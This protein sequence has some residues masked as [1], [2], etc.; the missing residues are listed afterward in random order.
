MVYLDDDL[1]SHPKLF[2]I[3]HQFGPTGPALILALHVAGIS[4]SRKFLTDGQIP[5]TF[6][7]SLR[8]IPNA[9]AIAKAMSK[10]ERRMWIRRRNGYE[11]KDWFVWN[12][13]AKEIKDLRERER[14]RKAAARNRVRPDNHA[15]GLQ[16]NSNV[17]A[18]PSGRTSGRTA[19]YHTHNHVPDHVSSSIGVPPYSPPKR[20]T[21]RKR[22][23]HDPVPAAMPA[24]GQL[25][26]ECPHVEECTNPRMCEYR[27]MAPTKYPLKQGAIAS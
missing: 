20:G 15:D 25:V 5:D 24:E 17:S 7:T 27:K 2:E 8:L 26:G 3:G 19:E 4:Y 9:P 13:S 22:K 23:T 11:I 12:K 1:P 10:G 6:L 21:S 14:A 18:P 16:D